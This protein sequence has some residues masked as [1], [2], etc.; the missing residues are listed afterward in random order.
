MSAA[1]TETAP[2]PRRLEGALLLA[3]SLI[4]GLTAGLPRMPPSAD[5]AQHEFI[6][7]ALRSM[8]DP[9]RFP[10]PPYEYALSSAN[11]LFLYAAWLLTLVLPVDLAAR[12]A[13]AAVVAALPLLAGRA[14]RHAGRSPLLGVVA[15]PLALGFAYR[16]GLCAYLLGVC[17]L[18]AALP[19]LDA[20]ARAP[21]G[22]R[23][24]RAAGWSAA[25]ALAHGSSMIFLLTLTAV[26]LLEG[27]RPL[28]AAALV[29]APAAGGF[30]VFALGWALFQSRVRGDTSSPNGY[31]IALGQRPGIVL[32]SLFGPLDGW[33]GVALPALCAL[34]LALLVRGA[35][36]G[37][38]ARYARAGALCAAQ[39]FLW[40]NEFGGAGLLFHRF[41]LPAALLLALAL[42]SA[43]PRP[44]WRAS[45]LLI[46]PLAMSAALW[47]LT[48][49]VDRAWRD[50]DPV[51]ARIEPGAAVASL[52]LAEIPWAMHVF[53]GAAARA[54]A[55]RGGVT[56]ND[57]SHLPQFPART[58]P[59]RVWARARLRLMHP[60]RFVPALDFRRFRYVIVRTTRRHDLAALTRA[61]APEGRLVLRSGRWMLYASQLP[62]HPIA[63]PEPPE[64]A[65]LPPDLAA[66]IAAQGVA[67]PFPRAPVR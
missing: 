39:F 29:A 3:A 7:A 23:A 33:V 2:G 8:G 6:L 24:L 40:P 47:P 43:T 61:M 10:S 57:F 67:F 14:A 65:P 56:N 18:L 63:A 28:R 46:V 4:V 20:L 42:P 9:Q 60:E 37:V 44:R 25:L 52:D 22:R 62:L 34:G 17:V 12:L 49:L 19:D 45:L 58:A 21:D 31:G 50:L 35:A 32:W 13:L 59:D 53:G 27:R 55:L 54:V 36:G 11:Q 15:A 64:P 38:H 48:R 51:I 5:L 26:T 66:R 16:W 30:A 1:P 41:A